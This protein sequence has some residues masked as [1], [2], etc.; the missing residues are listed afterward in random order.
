MT[1]SFYPRLMSDD[2]ALD[3]LAEARRPLEAAPHGCRY[4]GESDVG[5]VVKC[6]TCQKWFC[7]AMSSAGSSH[8]VTHLVKAKHKE[9]SLHADS[10]LGDSVLECYQCGNRNVLLLGFVPSKTEAIV[11]LLCREPCLHACSGLKGAGWEVDQWQ[12]IIEGKQFVDWLVRVPEGEDDESIAERTRRIPITFQQ[13]CGLEDLW[14]RRP[15]ATL[16]DYV[17][18]VNEES[19]VE[20]TRLSYQDARE[21][22]DI[23]TPLLMLEG[24]SDRIAKENQVQGGVSVKW[25]TSDHARLAWFVFQ[26][27]D[28]ETKIILGDE[29]KLTLPNWPSTGQSWQGAGIVIRTRQSSEEVCLELKQAVIIQGTIG[30]SDAVAK[31]AGQNGPWEANHGFKVSY[32]WKSTSFDRMQAALSAFAGKPDSMSHDIRNVLLGSANIDSAGFVGPALT[33]D[34]SAPNLPKPNHSQIYAVR[35]ALSTPVCL[36]QGPP[37]TGKTLTSATIVYR[38]IKSGGGPVLV[39]APSN[40]AVDHLALK[41][42]QTGLKVLRVSAKARED[43][44]TSVDFLSLHNMVRQVAST[45]N[46]SELQRLLDKDQIQELSKSEEARLKRLR[47]SVENQLIQGADVVCC[48]CVGA[49]DLRLKPFTFTRVL[50]DEIT[51]ATEPESLIPLVKGAKHAVLVGDHCQLGPTVLCKQAAKAGLNKSLFERLISTG[52]RPVRLEVQYRMHPA[53]SEFPSVAFYDGSLQNGVTAAERTARGFDWPNPSAPLMFHNNSGR[54][55]ISG[56]GT[57]YLNRAEADTVCKVVASML[58]AGLGGSQIGIVTPYEGQRAYLQAVLHRMLSG[59]SL[60]GNSGVASFEEI[61]IASVDAFQGREKD[62]IIVSCVRSNLV[63]G[64]GFLS[65]ARRLNV[66]IT[67]AKYGLLICGNVNTL[68]SVKPGARHNSIWHKLLAHLQKRSLIFEGPLDDLNVMQSVGKTEKKAPNLYFAGKRG[69]AASS[70]WSD[71]D[72]ASQT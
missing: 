48:T 53:L 65:D 13:M 25:E 15:D 58:R 14:R 41:I 29:L 21:Y 31:L 64:I 62:F 37:G 33:A 59:T 5:C 42:Y 12:S 60:V 1:K 36:I 46:F 10:P 30:A 26:R 67:R 7:N 19:P 11:V 70:G 16:L 66:A 69:G 18:A 43:I 45:M 6:S 27:E 56:S 72:L 24:E 17:A 4:C 32:V 2:E 52:V 57:S 23:F 71:F 54:E 49:G 51:Q 44:S 20:D 68:L 35:K 39:C 8:I 38:M 9:V 47:G 63:G 34:L 28:Y 3:L 55:E 40:I 61:E 22:A 50:I